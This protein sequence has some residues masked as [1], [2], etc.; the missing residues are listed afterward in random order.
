MTTIREQLLEALVATGYHEMEC[1]E[2]QQ[3]GQPSWHGQKCTACKAAEAV[4][5]AHECKTESIDLSTEMRGYL[6]ACVNVDKE[7]MDS[8]LENGNSTEQ[9]YAKLKAWAD[10]VLKTLGVGSEVAHE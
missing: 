8:D 9:E 4:K 1:D 3:C 7:Q 10:E 5:F 2:P 6:I